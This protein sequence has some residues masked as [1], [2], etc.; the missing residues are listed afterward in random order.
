MGT[1]HGLA[2]FSN[3]GSLL[4]RLAVPN[5]TNCMPTSWWSS[6]EVLA[7]CNLKLM[8]VPTSGATPT[9]LVRNPPGGFGFLNAYQVGGQTYLQVAP[10]CGT[11]TLAVLQ[12]TKSVPINLH[13][14]GGGADVVSTTDTSFALLSRNGCTGQNFISWWTP[15]T[16]AV[17]QVLGP[18]LTSGYVDVLGYPNPIS[19]GYNEDS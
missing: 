17:L 15:S 1:N 16:N 2:I 6:D 7:N 18:P 3:D 13:L 10:P 8:V 11:P 5:S 12:G 19:T 9:Q 14:Q 4:T